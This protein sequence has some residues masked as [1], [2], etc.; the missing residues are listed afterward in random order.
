MQ[1]SR[2]RLREARSALRK[3]IGTEKERA[4]VF[5]ALGDETRLKIVSK[6]AG[7][8]PRSITELT[9]DSTLT[10]QGVAKHLKVLE[11]AGLVHSTRA[12]RESLYQLDPEA[13]A[14][15]KTYLDLVSR[16]WDD[17]LVR[18]KSFVDE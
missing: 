11:D 8:E 2:N 14:E 9:L 1:K 12:G 5:A 18:L 10:R 17:A 4:A 6:L 3:Q 15:M 16:L 7:G 13:I